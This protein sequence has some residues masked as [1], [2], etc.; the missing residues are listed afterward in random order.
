MAIIDCE[1]VANHITNWI[2]EY[3][4]QAG[5]KTLVVELSGS[6]DSALTAL[7]CKRTGKSVLCV[8]FESSEDLIKTFANEQ[9]LSLMQIDLFT[10]PN[11]ICD[12]FYSQ[13]CYFDSN[14]TDALQECLHLPVLN[15]LA[16]TSKSLIVGTINRSLAH[17]V[18][19]FQK[20]GNGQVDI[21]PIA[22]LFRS[23]SQEL[24]IYL[25]ESMSDK[26]VYVEQFQTNGTYHVVTPGVRTILEIT[27]KEEQELGITYDEI[28]WADREN[29]RT[30]VQ[31]LDEGEPYTMAGIIFH[32]QDPARHPEFYRY[33]GRQ[34]Q[35]IARLHQLEK[36]SR[37][38]IN[39]N[40]PVCLIRQLEGLVR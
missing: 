35:I 40:L 18:R 6:V 28:E 34:Q 16:H 8:S 33:T 38:K 15:Y 19:Y 27:P 14:A 29:T 24:F 12:Q 39:S 7:L 13:G 4:D 22:D 9:G 1:K 10:I 37:H 32:H 21:N 5:I 17:I 20:Y 2:K 26:S 31:V 3:T 25:A 23:E 36:I 11:M 30:E